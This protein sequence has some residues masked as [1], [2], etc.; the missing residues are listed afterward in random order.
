MYSCEQYIA[1][2]IIQFRTAVT[3]HRCLNSLA[4]AYLTELCT[5]ITQSRSSCRLRSS[6]RNRLAVP[7]VKLSI[8]SLGRSPSLALLFWMLYLITLEIPPFP[9]VSSNVRLLK[10]FFICSVLTRRYSTLETLCLSALYKFIDWIYCSVDNKD[11]LTIR[12]T[13]QF[14]KFHTVVSQWPISTSTVPGNQS[15]DG[16]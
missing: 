14:H 10:N 5:P 9:F 8:G 2:F 7:S 12:V 16:Q 13:V 6:Y 3:V 4:P 1:A 15:R 11:K